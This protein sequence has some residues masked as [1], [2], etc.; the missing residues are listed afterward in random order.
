M[1][2]M[3]AKST[4]MNYK[5]EPRMAMLVNFFFSSISFSFVS[6]ALIFFSLMSALFT[7][8]S[9]SMLIKSLSS[10]TF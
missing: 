5:I 10:S 8:D 1:T 3:P 6:S 7:F 2:S 4:K 9:F